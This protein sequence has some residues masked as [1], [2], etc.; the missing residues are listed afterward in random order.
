MLGDHFQTKVSDEIRAMNM[1]PLEPHVDKIKKLFLVLLS[2]SADGEV[3]G[4]RNAI[5]RLVE[6][7]KSDLHA[8]AQ[9]LVD[10]LKPRER[11]VYRVKPPSQE[12]RAQDIA[13][14]C[15]EQ[16]DKGGVCHSVAER[17]FVQDMARKWGPL[18]PKQTAWLAKIR[19]RLL[20]N[21]KRGAA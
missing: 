11:I 14:W 19:A 9:V 7:S 18:S 12:A 2:S 6:N 4:A 5:M 10:G 15:L 1:N 13:E 8:L 21:P 20:A 17:K 3:I 16:F